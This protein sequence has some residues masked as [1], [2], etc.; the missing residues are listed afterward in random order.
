MKKI[1]VC[2]VLALMTTALVAQEQGKIRGGAN[3][4]FAIPSGGFGVAY[5][6][7]LGYNIADNMNVGARLGQ[8][9]M[10]SVS[11]DGAG[12][13][14]NTNILA[15]FTYFLNPGGGRFAPFAGVGTG[16]YM[17]GAVSVGDDGSSVEGG[18][19]FGGML[20]AGFELGWF[21]LAVEYNLIPSSPVVMTVG[22][23]PDRR[24]SYLGITLGFVIGGGRWG[25]R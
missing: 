25:G 23:A 12:A 17:L 7:F 3:F 2:V 14:A 6:L 18:T 21:R 24:N 1:I 10:I 20:T 5:D 15:T 11:D 22:D 19:L 4:G 16:V 8:A 13:S 9:A